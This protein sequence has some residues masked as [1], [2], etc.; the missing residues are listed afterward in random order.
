MPVRAFV[1][2]G[3]VLGPLLR[4][5]NS[6]YGTIMLTLTQRELL[7]FRQVARST[8]GRLPTSTMIHFSGNDAG[9]RLR[10]TNGGT[11]L[12]YRNFE[13]Q[14][15]PT[16]F[17]VQAS[18]LRSLERASNEAIVFRFDNGS[19]RCTAAHS[20]TLVSHLAAVD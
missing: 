12:H 3:A 8:F 7:H 13:P 18:H 6:N 4:F 19:G 16:T 15:T 11:S 20:T 2:A 10:L 1:Q 5:L 17:A 9:V 14:P